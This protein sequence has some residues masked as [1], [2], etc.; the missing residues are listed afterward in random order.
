MIPR[1]FLGV[2]TEL[3]PAAVAHVGEVRLLRR[4]VVDL[5]VAAQAVVRFGNH[6]PVDSVLGGELE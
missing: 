4:L 5:D 1:R 6:H 3:E 2:P